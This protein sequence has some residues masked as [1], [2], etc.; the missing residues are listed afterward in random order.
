MTEIGTGM[1]SVSSVLS[2]LTSSERTFVNTVRDALCR[3]VM[4]VLYEPVSQVLI[5]RMPTGLGSGSW[6]GFDLSRVGL[7][8]GSSVQQEG[9]GEAVGLIDGYRDVSYTLLHPLYW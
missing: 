5:Q 8:S 6:S 9:G 1:E 2:P 3:V 7:T 4:Y